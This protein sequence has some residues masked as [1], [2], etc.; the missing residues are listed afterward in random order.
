MLAWHSPAVGQESYSQNVTGYNTQSTVTC[1]DCSNPLPRSVLDSMMRP[2]CSACGGVSAHVEMHLTGTVEAYKTMS[3]NA[4][5]PAL[6]RRKGV[7]AR[8]VHKRDW[9]RKEGV[10]ANVRRQLNKR[11]N[12]YEEIITYAESGEPIHEVREA[13]TEHR[14]HGTARRAKL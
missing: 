6:S 3:Y 12:T 14:G 11:E 5:N 8:G 9:F 2:A 4:F 13:L 7:F 1:R 10:W